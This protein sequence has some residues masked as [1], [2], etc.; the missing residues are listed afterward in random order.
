MAKKIKIIPP[1][2]VYRIYFFKDKIVSY[3]PQVI[4]VLL[5]SKI[6]FSQQ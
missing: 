3:L 4:L 1:Y 6:K 2:G 5:N